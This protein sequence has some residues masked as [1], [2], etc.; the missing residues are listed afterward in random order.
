MSPI[1]GQTNPPKLV[2]MMPDEVTIPFIPDCPPF[3]GGFADRLKGLLFALRLAKD[4]K[5]ML[6][7]YWKK[8]LPLESI[9][10]TKQTQMKVLSE[11]EARSILEDG[12]TKTYNLIDQPHDKIL[13]K[14]G[15]F[16]FG[17]DNIFVIFANQFMALNQGDRKKQLHQ[18]FADHLEFSDQVKAKA[19]E[20]CPKPLKTNNQPIVGLQ[21]RIGQY[22]GSPWSDPFIDSKLNFGLMKKVTRRRMTDQR[23]VIF[24]ADAAEMGYCL[25]GIKGLNKLKA[26]WTYNNVHFELSR[27]ASQPSILDTLA[28]FYL[29]TQCTLIIHGRGEFGFLAA[30]IGG[31]DSLDYLEDL[32]MFERFVFKLNNK[33][34]KWNHSLYKRNIKFLT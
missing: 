34:S 22:A 15:Q 13:K 33:L 11:N 26:K 7:V 5:V 20:L 25:G 31:S 2:I 16:D 18:T 6:G 24:M 1:V 32:G 12:Q 23:S 19:S 27:K 9:F 10:D 28:Q 21:L 30:A 4:N 3:F 17:S 29:L 8:P 14:V